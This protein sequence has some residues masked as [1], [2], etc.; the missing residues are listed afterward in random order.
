M[1]S[2]WARVATL[3]VVG[4][5]TQACTTRRAGDT[6]GN[7]T[8]IGP[9]A[10]GGA[11]ATCGPGRQG[12]AC[13]TNGAAA[14]CGTLTN[15]VGNSVTCMMGTAIC[16]NGAWGACEGAHV[17][18]KSVRG[19]TLGAGGL[20]PLSTTTACADS[21][22]P[23]TCRD[24]ASN[25]SD[26][27]DAS[28]LQ[29]VA[30]GAGITLPAQGVCTGIQCQVV[31]ACGP[32][33]PTRLTGVVRDPANNNP[34]NNALVYVPL[35]PNNLPTLT[36]GPSCNACA[37]SQSIQAVAITQTGPD[38]TFTLDNVPA[39][40]VAPNAQIPLVVQLGNWRRT[41]TLPAVP[42]CQTTTVP[43]DSTRLPKNGGEGNMPRMAIATGS[44]DPLEC[45]LLKMG[46]QS[47]EFQPRG[48]TGHVDFYQDTGLDLPT[49]APVG[50]ALYSTAAD[51]NP[52]DLV[53]LP[54]GRQNQSAT[55]AGL[56]AD[57]A[58][59]GGR[60][61]ATHYSYGWLTTPPQFNG[62]AN[63]NLGAASYSYPVDSGINTTPPGGQA[64]ASWLQNVGVSTAPFVV[65]A[66]RH[67]VDSVNAPTTQWIFQDDPPNYPLYFSFDTPFGA[68]ASTDGGG[69]ICGRVD[70]SDFHVS[71]ADIAPAPSA[72]GLSCQ[73][74][75]DCGYTAT[76]TG[77]TGARGTCAPTQCSPSVPGSCPAGYACSGAV[78]GTCFQSP[79]P[80]GDCTGGDWL[81]Q[82]GA[83]PNRHCTN[84]TCT[85]AQ[86]CVLD[87]ECGRSEDCSGTPG[88]CTKTC[89]KDADCGPQALCSTA[90]QC[91]ACNSSADC[92]N[93]ACNGAIPPNTCSQS[94]NTFPLACLQTPMTSQEAALE[95][96]LLDLTACH[97]PVPVPVTGRT[98]QPATFQEVFQSPCAPGPADSGPPPGAHVVW[99]ALNWHAVVPNTAS[100]EFTLLTT[101]T[102][103]DGGSPDWIGDAAAPSPPANFL[104]TTSSPL[105]PLPGDT[106]RIETGGA[107]A[108]AGGAFDLAGV[109]S[110]DNLLL[111]VTLNPT[112]DNQGAPTL[113]DWHIVADCLPAE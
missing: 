39:T 29:G 71:T 53:L 57:Y 112:S 101:P 72:T 55:Y 92:G 6:T 31:L 11:P 4:L 20:R 48:G 46:I 36:S 105:P 62:V 104:E 64:L 49:P 56:V 95:F 79:G 73:T 8:T 63:W 1:R 26:V 100:I 16:L 12:C 82:T 47:T 60:V 25:V 76:C 58:D 74:N 66:A 9:A 44:N 111:T 94:G 97:T 102:P 80:A 13:A 33:T 14:A 3:L 99:R 113:L 87:E 88:T 15:R 85:P 83:N 108:G 10:S 22:D 103:L 77:A 68:S 84:R 109:K 23:N 75:A 17:V 35:D 90:G 40:D 89:T 93:R 18:T 50:T 38:G 43:S 78:P 96:M 61:L 110:Q 67:D 91:G 42:Q 107:D 41:I 32:L 59:Q 70:F 69:G 106:W 28:A 34:V 98:Y 7:G 37:S 19:V 5:A 45:L 2:T 65:T 30:D 21:C 81:C 27:G 86:T 51:L 54:C 52:Y 24:I